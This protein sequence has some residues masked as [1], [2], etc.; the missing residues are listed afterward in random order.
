TVAFRHHD[1]ASD[2]AEAIK[3]LFSP[4]FRNRI[5]ATIQSAPLDMPVIERV[6]DKLIVEVEAQLEKKGVS[7]ILDD[8]ARRWLAQKG[9]DPK[10]GARPMARLIQEQIKR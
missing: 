2:G 9:Y 6:V 5:D 7:I 8:D 1:T 10:M 3:R 4:E